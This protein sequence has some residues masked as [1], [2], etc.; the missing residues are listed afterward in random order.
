MQAEHENPKITK[1]SAKSP[2][3]KAR[4]KLPACSEFNVQ[5]QRMEKQIGHKR[6]RRA[7]VMHY[8]QLTEKQ[9]KQ[10]TTKA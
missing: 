10:K 5:I 6:W 7:T 8:M 2:N 3:N 1:A 4:N 9:V